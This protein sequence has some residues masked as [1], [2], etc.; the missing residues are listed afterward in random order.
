MEKLL[1]GI[2]GAI[3]L[4]ALAAPVKAYEYC[5]VEGGHVYKVS[6]NYVYGSA[7]PLAINTAEDIQSFPSVVSFPSSTGWATMVNSEQ[8]FSLVDGD[9]VTILGLMFEPDCTEQVFIYSPRYD[10]Y[11]YAPG[12]VIVPR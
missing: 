8:E 2:A 1:F 6:T 12:E 3:A 5:T 4:S 11:G 9:S 7:V 10:A